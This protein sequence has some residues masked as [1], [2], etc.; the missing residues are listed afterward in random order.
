VPRRKIENHERAAD[1]NTFGQRNQ[2]K[3]LRS[4]LSA[5]F[6]QPSS[7]RAFV[8]ILLILF[9]GSAEAQVLDKQVILERQTFWDNRDWEW[10]KQNIPIF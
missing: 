10:Y 8:V 7:L 6:V 3:I 5:F 4:N 1:S 2:P 9:F